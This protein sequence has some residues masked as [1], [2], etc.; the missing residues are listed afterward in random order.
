MSSFV[1]ETQELG[2]RDEFD[3]WVL[4]EVKRVLMMSNLMM[5]R[6]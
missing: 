2:D 5:L 4:A 1:F 3:L 6:F